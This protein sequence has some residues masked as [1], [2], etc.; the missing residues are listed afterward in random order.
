MP[1]GL[2]L[3]VAGIRRS[4]VLFPQPLASL[5]LALCIGHGFFAKRMARHW[6]NSLFRDDQYVNK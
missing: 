6:S 3:P 5:S 4:A 2:R 1:A